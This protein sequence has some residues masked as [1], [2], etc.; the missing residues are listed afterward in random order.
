MLTRADIIAALPPDIRKRA[1]WYCEL[2]ILAHAAAACCPT[3]AAVAADHAGRD[4]AIPLDITR[5][6]RCTEAAAF[7]AARIALW[8]PPLDWP[9]NW[10]A[11]YAGTI[12]PVEAEQEQPVETVR[13]K[14]GRK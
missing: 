6:I 4:E 10:L 7:Q 1:D 3:V 8:T 5:E 14:A 13:R 2:R 12:A 11:V 9:H